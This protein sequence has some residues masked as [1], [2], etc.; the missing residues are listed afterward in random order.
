M[1]RFAGLIGLLVVGSV[2]AI[3]E[4]TVV[5]WPGGAPGAKGSEEKDTPVLFVHLP[6][7]EKSVG[8]AVVVCPGGGYGGLAMT[9]EG[10]EVSE[11]LASHGIAGFTLRY[12]LA[13]NYGHPSPLQDAQRAIRY[14][15][16]HA[17]EYGIDP[18]KIGIWGFSAG[19]HLASTA[20]T[21]FAAGEPGAA[22]PIDRVS[23]RPNFSILAYPVITMD[24]SFTHAGSKR[25]L[26][27]ASPDAELV[28]SLSNEKQVTA[29]TP[30]AF[31]FQTN[32]DTA[33]PA[34]NAIAYFL[35]LR[36]AGVPAELHVYET[37]RHGVGMA[38][39]DPIL[40]TWTDRLLDWLS[41][42]KIL[43]PKE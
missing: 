30:P 4:D 9:Y 42:Q 5:L 35:A 28:E 24:D 21:H 40:G 41:V 18:E 38:V 6:D 10:N 33:V 7:K 20:S 27:G 12:R 31:L 37:G 23:C 32:A 3:A 2:S 34:E 11:W 19:G 17:K 39:E 43:K 25:N 15:R 13:P 1:S 36:K 22:D 8:A 26:L 29:E 14:V 16:A